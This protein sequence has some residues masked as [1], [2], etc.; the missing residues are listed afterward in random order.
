MPALSFDD[1]DKLTAE[2][3][4][5]DAAPTAK[6]RALTFDDFDALTAAPAKPELDGA[7]RVGGALFSGIASG[8]AGIPGMA[9][10]IGG[11]AQAGLEH[12][13][14]YVQ[15]RPYEEV[16]AE[17]AK[18]YAISPET[19]EKFGG[20]N[21]KKQAM[22]LLPDALDYKPEGRGERALEVG[23]M[24]LGG[25]APFRALRSGAALIGEVLAPAA[26]TV[27]AGTLADAAG[28]SPTAK[29][30]AE[31]IGGIAGGLGGAFAASRTTPAN[32]ILRDK[33]RGMEPAALERAQT[34]M[35]DAAA[36]GV[37]LSIDEAYAQVTGQQN[38]PLTNTRMAVERTPEGA[39]V[40]A[41]RMAGRP[42]QVDAAAR[43]GLRDIS[44]TLRAPGE[45]GPVIQ[46]E[47]RAAFNA[48][49]EARQLAGAMREAGPRISPQQ[50]GDIVQ[51]ELRGVYDR[52]VQ[53]R[54]DATGPLYREAEQAP[55]RIGVDRYLTGERPSEPVVTRPDAKPSFAQDAPAPLERFE[56][57][58]ADAA[59]PQAESLGR[60]IARNGGLELSDDVRATGLHDMKIPGL[61]KVAREGGKSIDGFWRPKLKEA[62]YFADDVDGYSTKDIT[63]ELLHRLQEEQRGRPTGLLGEPIS[64]KGRALSGYEADQYNS[65]VSQAETRLKEDLSHVGVDPDGLHPEIRDR[66]LGALVRNENTDAVDAYERVV[67]AMREP[68]APYVKSTTVEEPIY[69]PRFGQ[70]NPQNVIDYIDQQLP[71][72]KGDI[73]DALVKAREA[74]FNSAG[75]TDLTIRGLQG[76]RKGMNAQLNQAPRDVQSTVLGVR[77]RLDAEMEVAPEFRRA[78]EEYARQSRPLDAFEQD[79]RALGPVVEQEQRSG[80]FLMPSERVPE[81][82][83]T[84]SAARDFQA[85]AT[86]NARRAQERYITTQILQQVEDGRRN[87]NPE[88]LFKAL[89]TNADVLNQFPDVR[90]NLVNVAVARDG[91]ARAEANTY[92]GR[93]SREPDVAAAIKALFPKDPLPETAPEIGRTI[94]RLVERNPRATAELL[95]MHMEAT[96]NVASKEFSGKQSMTAGAKFSSALQGHPQQRQ[97][98]EAIVRALPDG[99]QRLRGFD[100]LIE[101]LEATGKA[102]GAQSA[103]AQLQREF[104]DAAHMGTLGKTVLA[105]K[106]GGTSML[107]QFREFAERA[108]LGKNMGQIA[109]ILTRPDSGR[110]LAELARTPTRASRAQ[111]LALRLT[112]MGK[113]GASQRQD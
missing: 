78:Q 33:V 84:P 29:A 113:T 60:F 64:K 18:D 98:F 85:A 40:F 30:V 25:G 77:N 6:S 76:A 110:L 82:L 58:A 71:N 39:A 11:L 12:A 86:P 27:A 42:A 108:S 70:V 87:I 61:P 95:R 56:A 24:F 38:N 101:I 83:N 5:A 3:P 57:G 35:D 32:T 16:H 68:P 4:K 10:D 53:A 37:N 102:P 112:Y 41:P 47:A 19:L 73:R 81:A 88:A 2:P 9:A 63:D 89:E 8:L 67:G 17:R 99:E 21:I 74:L 105:A 109:N 43:E 75:E 1:F 14:A 45:L 104:K 106:T 59:A 23:G 55:E 52:R 13:Q 100:R 46:Q 34:L 103:T 94:S 49:P 111:I 22:S 15:G 20:A 97:N 72:A 50:A 107:T 28:L 31:G 62:G 69:A 93:I 36:R 90:R 51:P 80:R 65:A 54:E 7:G 96:L 79:G 66:V 44:P 26:T 92:L 48:T 91:L